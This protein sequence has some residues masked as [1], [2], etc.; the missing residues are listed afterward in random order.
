MMIDTQHPERSIRRQCHL[1]GLNRTAFYT[2]PAEETALNLQLMRLIDEQYLQ[3]PF[4]G[5]PRMTAH[6]HWAGFA[7]NP[8]RVARLMQNM[9]LQGLF[10]RRKMTIPTPG[11]TIYPYLR[12]GLAITRPDQV[13]STDITYVPMTTGF[14]YLVAIIDW[15]SRY[16]LAWSLSNPLDGAFCLAALDQALANGQPETST[17]TRAPSSLPRRSPGDCWRRMCGSAWMAGVF[18]RQPQS[19]LPVN[20]AAYRLRSLSIRQV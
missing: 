1:I 19:V 5:Y 16:V 13:W 9:G 4:Y 6:L 7:V 8:K 20:P 10:P 11:H 15:Y 2:K 14:M 3:T 12:R 18:Q 17:P